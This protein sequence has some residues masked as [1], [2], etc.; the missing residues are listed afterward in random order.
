MHEPALTVS[1]LMRIEQAL[2]F[3]GERRSS[4]YAKVAK[5]L[6]PMPVK[7]GPRA[8]AIPVRELEAVNAARI[9]GKT[10]DEVRT[11]VARLHAERSR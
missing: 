11:L 8:C 2:V 9:A 5:S 6:L 10:D 1:A 7:L 3:T 4:Y